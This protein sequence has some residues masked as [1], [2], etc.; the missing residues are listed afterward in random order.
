MAAAL[1]QRE[2]TNMTNQL[3]HYDKWFTFIIFSFGLF[4]WFSLYCFIFYLYLRNRKAERK[5]LNH[6]SFMKSVNEKMQAHYRFCHVLVK[7]SL[8]T[9]VDSMEARMNMLAKTHKK[10]YKHRKENF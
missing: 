3:T 1:D 6:K 8:M 2:T 5:L 4:L 9:Y 10:I 7:L